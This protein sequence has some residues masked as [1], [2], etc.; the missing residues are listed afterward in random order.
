MKEHQNPESPEAIGR[1]LELARIA[2]D[3]GNATAFAK[4]LGASPQSWSN[5][6]T[7]D[8]RIGLDTALRMVKLYSVTLDWIFRG[9]TYGMPPELMAKIDRAQAQ[10]EKEA[11]QINSKPRRKPKRT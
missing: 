7:G 6:I 9:N 10:L 8:N 5:Y 11:A 1:R 2:L 4:T 3:R